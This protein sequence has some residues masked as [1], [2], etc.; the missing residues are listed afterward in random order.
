[1]IK[2]FTPQFSVYCRCSEKNNVYKKYVMKKRPFKFE[3]DS[4]FK[5][6]VLLSRFLLRIESFD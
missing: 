5:G 6:F 1:M 2:C 3:T 4:R